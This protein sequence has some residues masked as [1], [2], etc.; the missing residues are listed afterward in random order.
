[1]IAGKKK[2][3]HPFPESGR[4]QNFS[5]S[6]FSVKEAWFL[7]PETWFFGTLERY[8]LG[9]LAFQIKS[10]LHLLACC[11]VSSTNLNWVIC[12]LWNRPQSNL[13]FCCHQVLDFHFAL[14][15]FF[16]FSM[17]FTLPRYATH[18]PSHL[19]KNSNI[20]RCIINF[21]KGLGVIDGSSVQQ[22]NFL[23]LIYC[24][25]GT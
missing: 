17:P 14:R 25:S 9:L 16:F 15:N 7:T 13:I 12:L 1:M 11:A 8:L 24:T 23:I 3:T 6:P 22:G 2:L 10:S 18:S 5:P 20:L 21:T 19:G 4:N